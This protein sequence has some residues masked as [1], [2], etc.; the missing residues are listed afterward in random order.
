[1]ALEGLDLSCRE[2]A[3]SSLVVSLTLCFQYSN[4]AELSMG[5]YSFL[6]VRTPLGKDE[7]FVKEYTVYYT[8][9][10]LTVSLLT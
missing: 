1:M 4:Y 2:P 5:V 3:N 6:F 8:P 9:M 10:E 7:D